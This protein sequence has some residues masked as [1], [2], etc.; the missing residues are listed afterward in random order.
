MSIPSSTHLKSRKYPQKGQIHWITLPL[1][2]RQEHEPY[3]SEER[4][5]E[6]PLVCLN[7]V[8]EGFG[9]EGNGGEDGGQ[10]ELNGQD[11]VDL[12]DELHSDREG[13]FCDGAAELEE[14]MACQW[15]M[16]QKIRVGVVW[17]RARWMC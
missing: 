17:E 9:E 14:A 4:D 10:E 1:P 6:H 8:L 5:P 13:G 16:N 12:A 7:P 11:G 2:E 15:K 3:G